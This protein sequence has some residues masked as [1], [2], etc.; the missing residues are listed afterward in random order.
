MKVH[1]H[2][3]VCASCLLAKHEHILNIIFR[4]QFGITQ[5]LELNKFKQS[6]I[7]PL[8]HVNRSVLYHI[9]SPNKN[10]AAI[11]EEL[12]LHVYAPR[13]SF[14]KSHPAQDLVLRTNVTKPARP[15]CYQKYTC[16]N[17]CEFSHRLILLVSLCHKI[18][19]LRKQIF[20]KKVLI[21]YCF[22]ALLNYSKLIYM[23]LSRGQKSEVFF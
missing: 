16:F 10:V 7:W 9:Q 13:S 20:K 22:E 2:L 8:N 11:Q 12:L 4:H 18:T 17:D 21:S 3:R 1:A 14:L 5:A 6:F 23:D 19:F 15:V